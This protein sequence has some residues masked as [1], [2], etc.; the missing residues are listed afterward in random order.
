MQTKNVI[1]I[2]L[3]ITSLLTAL[4]LAGVPALAA[5]FIVLAIGLTATFYAGLSQNRIEYI[6]E[7]RQILEFSRSVISKGDHN[8]IKRVTAKYA[9]RI[10]PC[11][12]VIIWSQQEKDEPDFDR[13]ALLF[14]ENRVKDSRTCLSIDEIHPAPS[15]LDIS[16][17]VHS[18]LALPLYNRLD[19]HGVL[20]MVN[21]KLPAPVKP[22]QIELLT[23]LTEQFS[24]AVSQLLQAQIQ[25]ARQLDLIK[26]LVRAIEGQEPNFD[27]H[28]ETVAEISGLLGEKLGLIETERQELYYAALLHD[29][30]KIGPDFREDNEAAE[31]D[32]SD[33]AIRGAAI[34]E[35]IP[36]L[37]TAAESIRCHH[38]RYNGS[39]P[40]GLA[41]TEIPFYARIISVADLYDALTR[42]CPEEER[43]TPVQA[44]RVIKKASGSLLDPLVVVALEEIQDRLNQDGYQDSTE[45]IA[46]KI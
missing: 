35:D 15:G 41:G 37:R 32:V 27:R 24:W 9:A 45:P 5:A 13:E 26:A 8:E 1:V 44:V 23:Q 43:M 4:I 30:G 6:A 12:K 29:I 36:A 42:L 2:G 46:R 14:I 34:L 31:T 33:H 21:R 19:W 40:A 3:I 11:E 20:I 7:Q 18:L 39:G 16:G 22:R 38:E 25:P 17:Q 10:V 28:S